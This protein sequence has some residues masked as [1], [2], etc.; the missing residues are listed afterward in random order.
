MKYLSLDQTV[1]HD[2]SIATAIPH[3]LFDTTLSFG[4]CG[5][6]ITLLVEDGVVFNDMK[7]IAAHDGR[8]KQHRSTKL[9]GYLREIENSRWS[10]LLDKIGSRKAS[11]EVSIK[12]RAMMMTEPKNTCT[13]CSRK[14]HRLIRHHY[15][16]PHRFGGHETVEICGTCHDDFHHHEAILSTEAGIHRNQA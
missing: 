3:G 16:I 1:Q 15:P 6:V 11:K 5:L 2:P 7:D 12:A 9:Q 14:V 8:I 13:W 4:A 10:Y